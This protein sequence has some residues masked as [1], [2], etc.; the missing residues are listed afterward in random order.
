MRRVIDPAPSSRRGRLLAAISVLALAPAFA[1]TGVS[2]A[3]AD[4]AAGTTPPV[5]APLPNTGSATAARL[6]WQ[7]PAQI[8]EEQPTTLGVTGEL[9]G[10]ARIHAAIARDVLV[11]PSAPPPGGSAIPV[12]AST[13]PGSRFGAATHQVTVPATPHGGVVRLCGWVIPSA[14]GLPLASFDQ[15]YTLLDAPATVTTQLPPVI[16]AGTSFSVT[17]TGQTS[18][19]SRRVLAMGE[20][21]AG[22][23]CRDLRKGASGSRPLQG[24]W[25]VGNGAYSRK[26][27]LRFRAKA[28]GPMLLCLQVVEIKDRV[29]E[30]EFAVVVNVAE[31]LKCER[32]QATM[33]LRGRD[34]STIRSRRDAA[35]KRLDAAKK[36]SAPKRKA[37]LKKKKA[38]DKRIASARKQW[39]KAKGGAK[40]S[41]SRRLAS[42]RRTEAR[43]MKTARR[44]YSRVERTVKR[45]RTTWKRHL[46]GVRLIEQTIKRTQKD[47]GKYCSPAAAKAAP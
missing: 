18:G 26:V 4:Q 34:L 1:A 20:P 35:K 16:R 19:P 39:R 43:R 23:Q 27:N 41:A 15:A 33:R 21:A 32:A 31:S 7:P 6:T 2:T 14:G 3:G 10:Q 46:R 36:K 13:T 11:C 5:D 47:L 38:S 22:Q 24:V 25:G 12:G 44:P 37:Y 9:D 42:V 30:A 40:R 45:N 28:T 17:F 8:H 29:P